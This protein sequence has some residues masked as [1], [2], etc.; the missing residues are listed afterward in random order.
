MLD[1]ERVAACVI[2]GLVGVVEKLLTLLPYNIS[3]RIV[4]QLHLQ[5]CLIQGLLPQVKQCQ[6]L[7]L[8]L[9]LRLSL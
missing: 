1:T 9:L 3:E 4:R 7:A 6:L 8:L 2:F 5:L